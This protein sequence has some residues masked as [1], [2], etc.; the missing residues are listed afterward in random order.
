MTTVDKIKAV[1]TLLQVAMTAAAVWWIIRDGRRTRRD[2]AERT[3][4]IAE[5]AVG[6]QNA[7][8]GSR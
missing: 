3:R 5:W 4:N 8:K 7:N 2:R 1:C 6:S